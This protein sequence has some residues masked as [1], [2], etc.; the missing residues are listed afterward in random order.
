MAKA[1]IHHCIYFRILN[2]ACLERVCALRTIPYAGDTFVDAVC[3]IWNTDREDECE[4]AKVVSACVS[5]GGSSMSGL[6]LV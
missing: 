4:G 3:R 5:A 1:C 2:G 6:E